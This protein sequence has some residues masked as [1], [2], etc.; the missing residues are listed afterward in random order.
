M[1]IILRRSF[2]YGLVEIQQKELVV[3]EKAES[4]LSI[5][6]IHFK[7]IKYQASS[8]QLLLSLSNSTL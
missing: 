8:T 7:Y 6:Q 3:W 4:I 5:F 2:L 1:E